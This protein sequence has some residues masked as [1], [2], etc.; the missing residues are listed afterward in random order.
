MP[1]L[2]STVPVFGTTQVDLQFFKRD[3][4]AVGLSKQGLA[5]VSRRINKILKPRFEC[6]SMTT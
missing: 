1:N 2:K 6:V 3:V 5:V 4:L